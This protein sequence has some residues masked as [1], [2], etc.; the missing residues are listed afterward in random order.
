[1]KNIFNYILLLGFILTIISCQKRDI[2][3]IPTKLAAVSNLQYTLTG[4]TVTLSWSLPT[5]KDS[6]SVTVN[7]GVAPIPLKMGSTSYKYGIVETN[8]AYGF[9]VKISDIQGNTSLGQTVRFTRDGAS[10]VK[11]VSA[12]QNDNGVLLTWSSPDQPVAK[13]EIKAGDNTIDLGSTV[14]SYQI[15][16]LPA[17]SYMIS[18]VTTNSAG[19]VSNTVYLP[20]KVGATMIGY[21]GVYADSTA[22]MSLGDDDEIAGGQWLFKNYPK[23]RYISFDQVKNGTVDLTQ[24]R[25]MWWNFDVVAGHIMPAIATDPTVVSK[26]TQYYKDGG[27][28]LLN[29]YAIQYFWTL[30][31]IT[32]NYFMGFDEGPGG[33]NPDIWG[34]GVNIHEKHDQSS[35]PLYKGI[36]MTTQSD[37]RITFPVIGSGWKE[38]HNAVIVRIPEFEGGLPN[39]N[40]TAYTKFVSD[41]NAVWLGQW[42]GIGDYYMAGVLELK[43]KDDFQGS[44]IFIG[45]GGIEW[46]Q[47][48]GNVYQSTIELLYKN[49]LD[50]LK[51]K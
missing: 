45:I 1:M 21:L 26:M 41:N 3:V 38:N 39:D 22:L 28:L 29:Q 12:V 30:G 25:V 44:G 20:F 13:I 50:Y 2:I 49:A 5:G 16:N 34:V 40:E 17:A 33:F 43:P 46:H 14:T 9:T 18:F 27:N 19:K 35:H 32:Q 7:D 10:P 47:N 11:S 8:K 42:D 48:T 4:D 31:R 15:N 24:I 23:S 37:G 36:T 6:L 51:T